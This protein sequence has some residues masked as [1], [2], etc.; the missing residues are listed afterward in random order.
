MSKNFNVYGALIQKSTAGLGITIIVWRQQEMEARINHGNGRQESLRQL[1]CNVLMGSL[2]GQFSSRLLSLWQRHV[3]GIHCLT[4]LS[5]L[6][7][8]GK[9]ILWFACKSLHRTTP[10]SGT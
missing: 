9:W 7:C 10:R 6:T 5:Q 8:D 2:M 3:S 4:L 1:G